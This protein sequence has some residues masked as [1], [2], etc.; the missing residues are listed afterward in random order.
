METSPLQ[1]HKL[2]ENFFN[3]ISLPKLANH[4]H[5][6]LLSTLACCIT[7]AI[8]RILSSFFFPKTYNSLQGVR[9][10]NW[11]IHFVSMF[12]CCLIVYLSVPL[13]FDKELEKDKVFGYN[14]YAGNVYAISCGIIFGIY[15]SYHALQSVLPVISKIPTSLCLI[16]GVSNIILNLLNIIWFKKMIDAL[17]KRFGSNDKVEVKKHLKSKEISYHNTVTYSATKIETKSKSA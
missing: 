16:Y 10:V 5:V 1:Q 12:H 11:D 9:R 13:L 3:A 14:T 17:L 6:L 15:M 2:F 4:W 7:L 8:S